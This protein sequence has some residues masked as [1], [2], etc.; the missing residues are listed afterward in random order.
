VLKSSSG[1]V[2][3]RTPVEIREVKQLWS[4]DLSLA[5]CFFGLRKC[6]HR[7]LFGGVR[8]RIGRR[9]ASFLELRNV[10]SAVLGVVI[11]SCCV[12]V[13]H[14]LVWSSSPHS[15]NRHRATWRRLSRGSRGLDFHLVLAPT[16][17]DQTSYLDGPI[18]H[19]T[20]GASCL[21]ERGFVPRPSHLVFWNKRREHNTLPCREQGTVNVKARTVFRIITFLHSALHRSPKMFY[22]K[23]IQKD[24]Q[25]RFT[26][27]VKKMEECLKDYS[28]PESYVSISGKPPEIDPRRS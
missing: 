14:R 7:S 12:A 18:F 3:V 23:A 8:Q 22:Y 26:V 17:L 1:K 15:H 16:S 20:S 5:V 28:R 21:L 27:A 10:A 6:W 13:D 11:F 4:P 9:T 25:L 19:G 24:L 2:P